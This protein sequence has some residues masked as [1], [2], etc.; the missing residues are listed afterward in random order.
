MQKG[1]PARKYSQAGRLHSIIRLLDVRR[2]M[3]LDDLAEECAV[4]R[5]TIHRDLN[6][7]AEAGYPLYSEW[8]GGKKTYSFL[9]DSR[10]IPPITF[11]LNQV[12]SLYLLRSLA[13]NLAGTV[14]KANIDE[15]FRS[16]NSVLPDRYAAHLERIARVA[17]PVLQGTRDYTTVSPQL[18]KLLQALLHQFRIS[19]AYTKKG[20]ARPDIY[21]TDPYTLIFHKGGIYLLGYAHGRREMR[22]FALERVHDI[23]VSRERFDIPDD[24]Q[25]ESHFEHAF[26]LVR[27]TPM[28]IRIR[29]SPVVAQTIRERTW[30]PGQQITEED[31]GWITIE[32]EAAGELELTAWVLSYG[33]HAEL[34]E[35]ASLRDE[36]TRQLESAL[37]RYRGQHGSPA[38]SPHPASLRSRPLPTNK[39]PRSRKQ[40]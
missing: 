40:T 14:F 3:T 2:G 33:M 22:L 18:E 35:P 5:R 16:I 31:D 32:F 17:L 11:T 38:G 12:M 7:I 10:S 9:N 26:G 20:A 6:A 19:L 15:L 24:Y 21:D 8:L 37:G 36:I 27:D 30:S 29:F 13:A 28:A 23:E 34:L 1:K 4:D 25:P 39:P